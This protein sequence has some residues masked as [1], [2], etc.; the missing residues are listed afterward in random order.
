M[1]SF[2]KAKKALEVASRRYRPNRL[3]RS[4]REIRAE[5]ESGGCTMAQESRGFGE[6]DARLWVS[7]LGQM[8]LIGLIRRGQ[9]RGFG[10]IAKAS[11]VT[12]W[13]IKA[14]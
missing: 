1:P 14:E 13:L 11:E 9:S 4:D 12:E 2:A 5:E 10:F 8:G 7:G 3:Y 6:A